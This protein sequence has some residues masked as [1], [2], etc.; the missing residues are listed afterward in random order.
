MFT[1]NAEYSFL[2]VRI[3]LYVMKIAAQLLLHQD[4][5]VANSSFT[6]LVALSC[7]VPVKPDYVIRKFYIIFLPDSHQPTIR[8]VAFALVVQSRLS[9]INAKTVFSPTRVYVQV[10]VNPIQLFNMHEIYQPH[11]PHVVLFVVPGESLIPKRRQCGGNEQT[12]AWTNGRLVLVKPVLNTTNKTNKFDQ[13]LRKS[14]T[15]L[16]VHGN[17]LQFTPTCPKCTSL[18]KTFL[19]S[20]DDCCQTF[21][22]PIFGFFQ[23]AADGRNSKEGWNA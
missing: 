6:V 18:Q 7:S 12:K 2:L 8:L 5:I 20:L 11:F 3:S 4:D 23:M 15:C 17:I 19:S 22:K 9:S 16:I 1:L 13:Q 10:T 14:D 21:R